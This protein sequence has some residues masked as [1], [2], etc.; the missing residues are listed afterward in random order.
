MVDNINFDASKLIEQ[1]QNINQQQAGKQTAAHD[2]SFK[3]MVESLISEVDEAQ[4][5][6]DVSIENLAKGDENTSIQEVVSKMNEAEM[7]FRL[8]KEVRDKLVRA[9]KDVTSIQV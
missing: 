2:D 5:T 8:M 6:A 1:A 7:A 9:Y 3:N 4:K